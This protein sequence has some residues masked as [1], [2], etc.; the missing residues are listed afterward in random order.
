MYIYCSKSLFTKRV[1]TA[2][3]TYELDDV[4]SVHLVY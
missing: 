2:H 4:Y 3:T 1:P